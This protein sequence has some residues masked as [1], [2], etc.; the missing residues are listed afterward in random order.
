MGI[1][2]T[3]I[4]DGKP[5]ERETAQA[6]EAASKFI[7][8]ALKNIDGARQ[9]VPREAFSALDKIQAGLMGTSSFCIRYAEGIH[10]Y[11]ER[12]IARQE[13][14]STLERAEKSLRKRK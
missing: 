3:L 6:Y 8:E 5:V 12:D 10:R 2:T 7:K 13:A 14:M 9:L 4:I 11:G 1:E